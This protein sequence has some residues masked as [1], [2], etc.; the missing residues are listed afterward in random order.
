MI[1]GKHAF[2]KHVQS[3]MP[4]CGVGTTGT[5]NEQGPTQPLMSIAGIAQFAVPTP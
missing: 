1:A 2:L 4:V 5:R 3:G